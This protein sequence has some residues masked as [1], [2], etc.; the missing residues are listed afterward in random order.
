MANK[1]FRVI[2]GIIIVCGVLFGIYYVLPG[3][4]KNPITQAYQEATNKYASTAFD[5]LKKAGVPK[6]EGV[7][8][9][10]MMTN[11]LGDHTWIIAPNGNGVDKESGNGVM[12]VYCDGYKC[13]ISIQ[14]AKQTD[15]NNTYSQAHVRLVFN[16]TFTG[17]QITGIEF[18][19]VEVDDTNVWVKGSSANDADTYYHET[20]DFLC[21]GLQV[22]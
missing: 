11:A 21:N 13:D 17:G 15:T 22:E 10:S 14:D 18:P 9:D 20:I 3:H 4:F 19:Q 1:I 12:T 8:F 6:H 7:T 2:L 5:T 16:V